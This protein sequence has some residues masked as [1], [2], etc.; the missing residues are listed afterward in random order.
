MSGKPMSQEKLEEIRELLAHPDVGFAL[1]SEIYYGAPLAGRLLGAIKS[2]YE[3]EQ[4]WRGQ[5]E[6]LAIDIDRLQIRVK[7]LE[8]VKR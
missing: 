2:L 7:F 4:Y 3:S 6:E 8:H 5:A 1:K